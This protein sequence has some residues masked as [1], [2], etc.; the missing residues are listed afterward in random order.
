MGK[1]ATGVRGAGGLRQL[2]VEEMD[3]CRTRRLKLLLLLPRLH[4]LPGAV[5][6]GGCRRAILLVCAVVAANHPPLALL[7]VCTVG[8]GPR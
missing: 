6:R 1:S 8:I 7:S 3:I 5:I 4:P 2:Q